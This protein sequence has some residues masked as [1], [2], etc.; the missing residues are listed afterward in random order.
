MTTV[1]DLKDLDSRTR[2]LVKRAADGDEI[3]ITADDI[4]V[5]K[6]VATNGNAKA[7]KL[8]K[9]SNDFSLPELHLG[10]P[11]STPK[12]GEIAEE[13]FDGK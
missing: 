10:T 11:K 6:I 7:K 9:E 5:A 1:A 4:L 3:L 2:D 12:S 8:G 13:M